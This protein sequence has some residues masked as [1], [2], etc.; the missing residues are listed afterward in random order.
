[1]LK[2]SITDKPLRVGRGFVLSVGVMGGSLSLVEYMALG[3]GG[4]DD[5][6]VRFLPGS[7][8]LLRC[9]CHYP[10]SVLYT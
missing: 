9:Y 10:C 6:Q 2:L 4:G 7:V 3:F 5:G 8:L 1:M